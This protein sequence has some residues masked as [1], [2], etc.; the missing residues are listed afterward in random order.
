MAKTLESLESPFLDEE[1]LPTERRHSEW[2]PALT[3]RRAEDLDGESLEEG[4]ESE[5]ESSYDDREP[6]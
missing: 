5:R 1:I 4:D 6:G 2:R 3:R